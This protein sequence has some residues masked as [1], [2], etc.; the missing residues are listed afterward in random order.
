MEAPDAP[1]PKHSFERLF[2]CVRPVAG[3]GRGH[4]ALAG[5]GGGKV[6]G[7]ARQLVV[8]D[9]GPGVRRWPDQ[10]GAARTVRSVEAGYRA[11]DAIV[12]QWQAPDRRAPCRVAKAQNQE[13]SE[14]RKTPQSVSR[15]RE[16]K[17]AG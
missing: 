4:T 13:A 12:G 16:R 3:R 15:F 9:A 14:A 2:S 17:G 1:I 5:T 6:D 7:G 11:L 8:H 10:R